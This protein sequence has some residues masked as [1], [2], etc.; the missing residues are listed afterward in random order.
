MGKWEKELCEACVKNDL[1]KV[2]ALL[3]SSI[4]EY[5]M[6]N[7]GFNEN[8]ELEHPLLICA[9]YGYLEMLQLLL[10]YS[11]KTKYFDINYKNK[12]QEDTLL[13]ASRWGHIEIVKYL[14]ETPELKEKINIYTQDEKKEDVFMMSCKSSNIKLIKFL[15]EESSFKDIWDLNKVNTEGKNILMLAGRSA[16]QEII[17]YL[18]NQKDSIDLLHKNKKGEDIFLFLCEMIYRPSNGAFERLYIE[19]SKFKFLNILKFFLFDKNL[20]ISDYNRKYL[21]N[22][23]NIFEEALDLIEKKDLNDILNN[24][25][26]KSTKNNIKKI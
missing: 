17:S 14:L 8:N 24:T 5:I 11:D 3:S 26:M 19:K 2:Q 10:N 12:H 13:L 4:Y 6:K 20:V 23:K 9:N 7:E 15:L 1:K 16:N 25:L 21:N 18:L 22:E